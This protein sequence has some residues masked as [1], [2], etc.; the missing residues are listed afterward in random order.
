MDIVDFT[1]SAEVNDGYRYLFVAVDSFT[2][3]CHAVPIK[4]K[5]PEETVRAMK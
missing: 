5:E 3:L 2:K 1:R 4:D